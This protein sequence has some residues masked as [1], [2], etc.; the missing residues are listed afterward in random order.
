MAK[1]VFLLLLLCCGW[2]TANYDFIIA[3]GGTAGCVT[4]ERLSRNP[5]V[6][7]LLLEQ[8]DDVSDIMSTVVGF[9]NAPIFGAGGNIS[10]LSTQNYFTKYLYSQETS[11]SGRSLVFPVP[12]GFGAD[13]FNGNA[14]SRFSSEDLDSWNNPLWTYNA[15]LNA[16][17]D[18]E[19]CQGPACNPAYHGLNGSIVSNT[20]STN[21]FQQG[22]MNLMPSIFEVPFNNDSNGPTATGVSL[23]H[24]NI[25]SVNG[26]PIRQDT[27]SKIL[28]PVLNRPNLHV[29]TGV[30]VQK[31]DFSPSNKH[32]VIYEHEGNIYRQKALKEIIISMG[33]INSPTLLLRSGVGNCNKL[34]QLNIQCKINN[35]HVGQNFQDAVLSAMIFTVL[36]LPAQPA[37]PGALSVAYYRSSTFAGEGTDMEVAISSVSPLGNTFLV[38]LAQLRH[39]ATGEITLY[40]DN[41]YRPPLFN[42]NFW[43]TS[44]DAA[45]LVEQVKKVRSLMSAYSSSTGLPVIELSPGYTALPLGASDATIE[46]YLRSV[47]NAQYHA[48][49]TCSMNKV[50]DGRLRLLKGDG[51]IQPGIRIVD[52]SVV[53]EKPRT[54]ST[55][56]GA[57]FIASYGSDLIAQNWYI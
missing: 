41:I 3:G 19:K 54:H 47:V 45:P 14:W 20:F 27:F 43:P 38:Q 28:K 21:T 46:T 55:S 31:I 44:A 18:I 52:N 4:A 35:P 13:V 32:W 56:S 2:V 40:N 22:I 51:T 15:T 26:Q 8:G 10:L 53:P 49:G 24:R 23:M 17:K 7:V 6:K 37:P 39:N 16:W 25:E 33:V 5:R 9:W 42:F 57:M 11:L 48:I 50:V 1:V 30:N 29:K 12:L 36:S 34:S